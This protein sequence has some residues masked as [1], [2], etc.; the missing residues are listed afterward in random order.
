MKR[1]PLKY[2]RVDVGL[3]FDRLVILRVLSAEKCIARCD[4]GT[5]KEFWSANI[6]K[7]QTGSCGCLMSVARER[8]TGVPLLATVWKKA[9]R[10]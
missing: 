7:G 5:E 4:C 6:S 9:A 10:E 2:P 1:G 8:S 3:R